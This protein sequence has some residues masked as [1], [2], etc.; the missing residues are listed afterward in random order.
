MRI[1]LTYDLR[2]DYLAEGYGEEETAEF[3]QP[4]TIDALDGA[5]ASLGHR[6]ERIG[7]VRALT[8]ALAA[9]RR[10][11]LVFNIAEGLE[12]FGREAQVPA[13]LEAHGIPCTFSDTLVMSVCLHKGMT[14]DVLR[15]R[16]LP[17][18]ASAVITDPADCSRLTLTPP[19][20]AKPVAEG[21]GKGVTP[22]GVVR[23][24]EDLPGVC[25]R[26]ME[27]YRQPVL[28]ET[29]LPGREFTV[30]ILGT[31]ERSR[32]VGA[33]EVVLKDGA[34]PGVYSYEN[35]ERCEE[36][37]EYV[38]V[39]DATARRAE[40]AALDA[41]RAIGG[42]DAGRIDLRC[43]ETG[44]PYLLEINPLAGMHPSHSDLPILCTQAG[45][46]YRELVRT[47]VESA[48]ERIGASRVRTAA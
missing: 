47:I 8:R 33:L 29:Y 13:L 12:G 36:L 41:W 42:R 3:D 34:E 4:S 39:R 26:L 20:F 2:D 31:G 15:A 24:L 10:W 28:V 48:R 38:L 32:A 46:P 9:G 40:A 16:G 19:L 27:R 14:K 25:T 11:D 18:P 45:I 23:R 1:G 21:T 6:V 7:N 5:L 30:G 37:V 35:K 43:D 17:T 44:A 22:E